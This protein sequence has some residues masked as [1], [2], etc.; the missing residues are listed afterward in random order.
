MQPPPSHRPDSKPPLRPGDM[1]EERQSAPTGFALPQ[2]IDLRSWVI[3]CA[4][5]PASGRPRDRPWT[6]L[7]DDR[8]AS[9]SGWA[10]VGSAD[11][12]LIPLVRAPTQQSDAPRPTVHMG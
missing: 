12:L 2:Y 7:L 9:L 5:T 11:A 10:V 4:T 8:N 1:K 3:L 6:T